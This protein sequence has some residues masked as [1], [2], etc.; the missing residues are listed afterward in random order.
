VVGED[1]VVLDVGELVGREEILRRDDVLAL[2]L[3]ARDVGIK[4]DR[5][6]G[7]IAADL[8][9]PRIALRIIE[10]RQDDR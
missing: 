7:V 4:I 1:I 3:A 6:V 10:R 2:L 5:P 8:D 9:A